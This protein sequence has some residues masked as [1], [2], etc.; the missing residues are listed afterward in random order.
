MKKTFKLLS[1]GFAALVA[2]SFTSCSDDKDEPAD[3]YET[4]T[5]GF[6]NVSADLIGGPTSYGANLYFGDPAQI[7]KGYIAKIYDDTYAQFPINYAEQQWVDGQPWQYTFYNGGL[8]LSNWH[9]M[10]GD[11]FENQ[12]S[13]YNT[14]SPSGG[15]FVVAFGASDNTD[16]SK[17]TYKDYDGCGRV[18]ITDSRGY[19]VASLGDK[20]RVNGDDED[21][22]FKS[23]MLTNTTYDYLTMKNGNAYASALNE[24][25]Q[26]WFKVQFI[27]FN[28]D[29]PNTR[30]SGCVEAYLANFNKDLA[31]GWTGIL[32]EWIE[33]DLSPL[34]EA[35]ILVVNFVGSDTGKWGLN[36]PKYCALDNFVITVEKD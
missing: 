9:D 21:A 6:K 23:V 29:E 12:L 25:N 4:V 7:T 31:G 11:T 32:D 26:G 19:G 22:F 15:N 30:P 17:A 18:Y 8:A 34:P 27:S 3:K 28:D 24:E 13:V 2:M 1:F 14:T 10:T 5:I 36:T 35:S 16:P 20:N 33:V